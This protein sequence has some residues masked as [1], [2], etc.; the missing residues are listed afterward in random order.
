MDNG[1]PYIISELLEGQTLRGRLTKPPTRTSRWS[2]SVKNQCFG[3]GR[4]RRQQDEIDYAIQIAR[5]LAAAHD[6]GIVHRDLK[7]ENVFVTSDGQVKILD[8]GLAKLI[9]VEPPACRRD[10]GTDENR[11]H[12]A[13]HAARDHRLDGARAGPGTGGRLPLRHLRVRRDALRDAVGPACVQRRDD[14]GHDQRDY[15]SRSAQ[16][17]PVSERHIPPGLV[18]L[19]TAA[20]RRVRQ[21]AFSR[22]VI[23][24]SHSKRSRR[25]QRWTPTRLLSTTRADVVG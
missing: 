20:W 4:L 23:W 7:P 13:G 3:S 11:G 6:R 15:R 18:R 14:G 10:G 5:G 8:F 22:H 17:L 1:S 19:S 16:I 21:R 24:R 12:D 25:T 9:E 2:R